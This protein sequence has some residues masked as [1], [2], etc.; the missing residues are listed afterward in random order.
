MDLL[1]KAREIYFDNVSNFQKISALYKQALDKNYGGRFC[2]GEHCRAIFMIE[3][4]LDGDDSWGASPKAFYT[5][6]EAEKEAEVLKQKYHFVSECR[7]VT[8]KEKED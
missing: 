8:K 3:I 5:I 7:I 2:I 6:E 4:K 1:V